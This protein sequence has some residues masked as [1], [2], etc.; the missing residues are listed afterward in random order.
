MWGCLV[1]VKATTL[2]AEQFAQAQSSQPAVVGA[3]EAV[4]F[5]AVQFQ[6]VVEVAAAPG[7]P[8]AMVAAQPASAEL[9]EMCCRVALGFMYAA[10]A[11]ATF[12]AQTQ[13]FALPELVE[14]AIIIQAED[15]VPAA[16]FMSQHLMFPFAA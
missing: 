6:H 16:K 8:P 3:A 4:I 9:R 2:Q 7:V 11:I 10:A 13:T 15:F 5:A 1:A 14:T 12:G